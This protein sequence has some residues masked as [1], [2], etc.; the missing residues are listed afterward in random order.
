MADD[1]MDA[2]SLH[3]AVAAVCPIVG[4][5]I[6]DP[7]NRATWAVDFDSAATAAQ[8]TAAQSVVQN[9]TKTKPPLVDAIDVLVFKVLLNHEN[10]IRALENKA[11]ITAAQFKSGLAAVLGG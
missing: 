7:G 8:K 9:F 5:S 4:V 6:G 10:R 2:G 11:T 3:Q 1:V